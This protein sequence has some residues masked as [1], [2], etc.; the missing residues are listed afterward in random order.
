MAVIV[1]QGLR[2][3]V[4]PAT[5]I[6][7]FEATGETFDAFALPV[8]DM[9]L[10]RLGGR[11]ITVADSWACYF[12]FGYVDSNGDTQPID[13]TSWAALYW[14]V[15]DPITGELLFSRLMGKPISGNPNSWEEMEVT[16]ASNGE[17][18]IRIDTTEDLVTNGGMYR[19][20]FV[21][22]DLLTDKMRQT[23]GGGPVEILPERPV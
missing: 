12:V 21:M 10:R 15:S 20:D 13:I 3:T 23:F 17:V 2:I 14:N 7:M 4:K 22:V 8:T 5:D 16:D 11:A 6:D 1:N 9:L 18:L 19:H